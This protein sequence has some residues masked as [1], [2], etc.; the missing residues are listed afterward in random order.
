MRATTRKALT[1][2]MAL[3]AAGGVTAGIADA[4][5]KKHHG[6]KSTKAAKRN[7]R[8]DR[9]HF[10]GPPGRPFPRPEEL[11]G[12]TADKAKAAALDA[13]PGGTVRHAFKAPDGGP[14]GDVAY[15]VMVEKSDHS[16]V[17]VLLDKDFK[18][19]RTLDRPP[20]GPHGGAGG[21]G[22]PPNEPEL[23]GDDADKA[24]AAAQEAVPGGTVWRVSK[25]DP[26]E[27]TGAA[28]EAHVR[29]DDGSEVEVLMDG[30][31]KVIK[32]QAWEHPGP[33]PGMG[34]GPPGPPPPG[35][36]Y[37]PPPGPPPPGNPA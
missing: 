8:G 26:A 30:D 33:P 13:V 9:H 4:A 12:D 19:V 28:Y 29:K 34:D 6:K 15:V 21:P 37:G 35:A 2:L 25:E 24:R 27:N 23:T 31:F 17:L 14:D 3:A 16:P 5:K 7:A 11:T 32:T 22:S 18:L 10:G 36:G 1:W 20:H